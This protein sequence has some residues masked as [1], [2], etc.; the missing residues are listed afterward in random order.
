M[1]TTASDEHR[2]A[3]SE[4]VA[5]STPGFTAVNGRPSASPPEKH[6]SHPEQTKEP[7]E[8]STYRAIQPN[9]HQDRAP[10]PS[11][12]R[13]PRPENQLEHRSS[14]A[15]P[16][17]DR[18][19]QTPHSQ[20]PPDESRPQSVNGVAR[21]SSVSQPSMNHVNGSPQ[22]RKRSDSDEYNN[23]D[24]SAYHNHSLPPPPPDQRMYPP[25]T[26]G[27]PREPEHRSPPQPYPRQGPPH[28]YGRPA[29]APPHSSYPQPERHQLVR[30]EYDHNGD[31]HIAPAQQ[32]QPYY[33]DPDDAHLAHQLS[34][35]LHDGENGY[36]P[37]LPGR[38]QFMTPEEEDHHYG[39]YPSNMSAAQREADRKRRKRVFSNRT[40]TGCMT[41]R[42]RKKK[43]DEQHPECT[44]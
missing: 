27:R 41:C 18:S 15:P 25:D 37:P 21:T 33:Q 16:P 26:N 35:T 31:P 2:R 34:Q 36:E 42:R 20:G 5:R 3:D 39:E 23:A 22:K 12:S 11:S 38:E 44:F 24:P 8:G 1:A 14:P 19:Y 28:P 30:N 32:R 17:M 9:N 10:T 6:K 13:Q 4:S 43:C 40:K 29:Y 7:S